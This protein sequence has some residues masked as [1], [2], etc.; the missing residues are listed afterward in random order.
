MVS[1]F[2][3]APAVVDITD[4]KRPVQLTPQVI[5]MSGSIRL[6]CRFRSARRILERRRRHTLLAVA[7]DQIASAAGVWPNHPSHW[8]SA[9]AGADIAMVTYG[10]F[11]EALAPLVAAHH[12]EGK[13]SA[14]IPINDLYD[15]FNFGER[16]PFAIRSFLQTAKQ[17]WKMP[18]TLSVVERAGIARSAKLSGIRISGSGSDADRGGD[19]PDDGVGRLVLGFQ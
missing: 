7:A 15:E 18:P 16:T 1:G 10:P 19:Q 17:N 13:T 8:H 12:A 5:S 2:T 6:L 3:S 4:P 11:A 9:Q 14:V